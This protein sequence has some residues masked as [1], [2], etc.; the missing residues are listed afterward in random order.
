MYTG[1]ESRA[2]GSENKS[3]TPKTE[4]FRSSLNSKEGVAFTKYRNEQLNS[5]PKIR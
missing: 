4:Y 3:K 2:K 5:D 1:Y